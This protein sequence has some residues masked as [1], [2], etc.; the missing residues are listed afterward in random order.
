MSLTQKNLHKK[1]K[2]VKTVYFKDKSYNNPASKFQRSNT[3]GN[4][5]PSST[6]SAT[7]NI[8]SLSPSIDPSKNKDIEKLQNELMESKKLLLTYENKIKE[9]TE[10]LEKTNSIQFPG[11]EDHKLTIAIQSSY[12]VLIEILELVLIQSKNQKDYSY[13][14]QQEN[15]SCSMDVY[16]TSSIINN[17]EDKKVVVF[18]Q[19]QQILLF[20]LNTLNKLFKL[21]LEK[22]IDKVKNWNFNVLNTSINNISNIRS[23][24]D[25]KENISNI[26][27]LSYLSNQR[28][29]IQQQNNNNSMSSC[30]FIKKYF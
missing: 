24:K 28:N 2:N 5:I 22:Q 8:T 10:K 23:N 19:I 15:V 6:S 3:N 16:D 9:L 21:G 1:T 17:D 13:N 20:K 12:D 11:I 18:E 25:N 7:I 4:I 29:K 27:N 30:K 14:K 26:S